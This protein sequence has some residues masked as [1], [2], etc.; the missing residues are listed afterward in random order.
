MN[1]EEEE[2]SENKNIL[3]EES[4]EEEN[5]ED[6]D[7][8]S[9]DFDESD[10]ETEEEDS[11]DDSEDESPYDN[12]LSLEIY[13]DLKA[14]QERVKYLEIELNRYKDRECYHRIKEIKYLNKSINYV[15]Y[16]SMFY[17]LASSFYIVYLNHLMFQR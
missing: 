6:F 13:K 17:N 16:M 15:L 7:E 4:E 9:E 5:D 14:S 8:D 12:S 3:M 11:D 1:K 2:Y 10:D